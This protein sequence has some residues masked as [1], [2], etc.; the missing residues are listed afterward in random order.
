ME[1]SRLQVEQFSGSK[2]S[3]NVSKEACWQEDL[4]RLSWSNYGPLFACSTRTLGAHI[5]KQHIPML[6]AHS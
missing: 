4:L 2:W 1:T 5:N 6:P 3:T